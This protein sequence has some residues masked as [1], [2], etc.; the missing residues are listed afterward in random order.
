MGNGFEALKKFVQENNQGISDEFATFQK[1]V[2]VQIDHL[3][4]LTERI[5]FEKKTL[6][7]RQTD[8]EGQ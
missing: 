4:K 2:G 7:I 1:S 5:D 6:T 3:T 8:L